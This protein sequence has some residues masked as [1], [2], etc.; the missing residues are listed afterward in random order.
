MSGKIALLKR[1]LYG[2]KQQSGRQWASLLLDTV[3]GHGMEQSNADP[4]VFRMTREGKIELGFGS[5]CTV[6]DLIVAGTTVV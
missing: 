6:D 5:A 4:C 3:A 2:I 1:A